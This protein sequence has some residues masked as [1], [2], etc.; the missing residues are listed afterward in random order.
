MNAIPAQIAGVSRIIVTT[1]YRKFQKN[2]LIAAV[3]KELGLEEVYGVG[4]AQAIAA[5]AYGT[6]T[7]PRVNKIV[8]PGNAFV[9]EAKKQVFGSVDID[10]IAGPSEVVIVSD[11]FANPVFVAADLMAQAEHDESALAL[12]ITFSATQAEAIKESLIDQ[13]KHFSRKTIIQKALSKFGVILVVKQVKEAA[14]IVNNIAPEHLELLMESAESFA[15]KIDAAGAIF[16]GANSCETVG[17]Y[18]AGPNHVLPTGGTSQFA[19]PLGVY[20]FIKRTNL[21]KYSRQAIT[22]HYRAIEQFALA[23][24]L[25]AHAH[26][27]RVRVERN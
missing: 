1:P 18:F 20:D 21:I 25:D 16:F 6:A 11:E 3:F 26:S 17:D 5:L 2:P 10:V 22:K 24:K 7:I 15:E 14:E 13:V 4:G 9:A 19:S 23:E 27:V 8:G 12:A